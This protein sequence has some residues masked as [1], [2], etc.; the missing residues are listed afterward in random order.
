ME[1]M[2]FVRYPAVA[3]GCPR[4][5]E[6]AE[7]TSCDVGHGPAR[8]LNDALLV[9]LR[10]GQDVVQRLQRVAVENHL[11]LLVGAR[12][13]IPHRAQRWHHHCILVM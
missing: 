3:R 10:V 1:K 12:H 2:V 9:V 6:A 4:V 7:H 13:H 8:L 5:H 11:R